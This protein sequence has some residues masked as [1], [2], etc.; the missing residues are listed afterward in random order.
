MKEFNICLV[1][2]FT[3]S[4]LLPTCLDQFKFVQLGDE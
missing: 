3:A 1:L 4:C 2:N